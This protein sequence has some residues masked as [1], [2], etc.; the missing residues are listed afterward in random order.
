MLELQELREQVKQ[1]KE[2]PREENSITRLSLVLITS[3]SFFLRGFKMICKIFGVVTF[4]K[5]EGDNT[6]FDT[7]VVRNKHICFHIGRDLVSGHR[8]LVQNPCRS[9]WLFY[10]LPWRLMGSRVTK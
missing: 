5:D 3:L 4:R 7:Q 1:I 10:E 8:H 6:F 2:V 9:R